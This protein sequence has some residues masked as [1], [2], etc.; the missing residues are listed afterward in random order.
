MSINYIEGIK[1]GIFRRIYDLPTIIKIDDHPNLSDKLKNIGKDIGDRMA[2]IVMQ[3]IDSS[4]H[5]KR[6]P[7]D[8]THHYLPEVKFTVLHL[9]GNVNDSPS[10]NLKDRKITIQLTG[11][12]DLKQG[13]AL[14]HAVVD[15]AGKTF[16]KK[17]A[18]YKTSYDAVQT[19][20]IYCTGTITTSE[21]SNPLIDDVA[22]SIWKE[23]KPEK[24][25]TDKKS[26]L[27]TALTLVAIGL[28]IAKACV[29][30]TT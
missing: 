25:T 24:E 8:L 4:P 16:E 30:I 18:E 1:S 3:H 10:Y 17:F 5:V 11:N 21:D 22:F 20:K 27:I 19:E 9:P 14:F 13:K 2:T 26:N 15:I 28:L 29:K 12:G 6:D 23:R 7:L